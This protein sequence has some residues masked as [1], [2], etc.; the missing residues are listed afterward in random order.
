MKKLLSLLLLLLPV[1]AFAQTLPITMQF[2]GPN[3]AVNSKD[4]IQY[5]YTGKAGGP[6][7]FYNAEYIRSIFQHKITLTNTGSSGPSTL[8]GNTLNIPNYS[9]GTT[10]NV[11]TFNNSGS[12][13]S[14]GATFNGA[15]AITISYNSI[16]AQVAGT[17]LTPSSTNTV[18]NKDLT[19]GTNT[20]PTFNQ[21][22][23]G[24]AGSVANAITNGYGVLT[25]TYNGSSAKTIIIDSTILKS[26][27]SSLADYNILMTGINGKFTLPSLTN[28][29]VLFSNGTTISQDNNNFYYD[30]STHLLSVG[31]AGDFSGSNTINIYGAY[32]AYEPQ[33]AIGTVTNATLTPGIS[34]STSRGTG[35]SP[36]INNTGDLIGT[37]SFWAYTGSSPAYTYMAGI[38]GTAVGTTSTNLGGQLDFYVKANNGS[39]SSAMTILNSGLIGMGITTPSAGLLSVIKST[40]AQLVL[41]ADNVSSRVYF[42][43]DAAGDHLTL[44]S[45]GST[46]N[47]LL[48]VNGNISN[49]IYSISSNAFNST[50]ALGSNGDRWFGGGSRTNVANYLYGGASFNTIVNAFATQINVYTLTA[51]DS[52]TESYFGSSGVRTA[53]T[54][55][56]AWVGE[57]AIQAPL[58]STVTPGSSIPTNTNAL[59]LNNANV[60]SSGTNNWAAANNYALYVNLGKVNIQGLTATKIIFTDANKNLTSTG[61]GTSSQFLMADGSLNSSTYLTSLSGAILTTGSQTSLTGDKNSNANWVFGTVGV[62]TGT[63]TLAGKLQTAET[64]TSTIR[65]AIFGQ[66][67]SDANG[68]KIYGRKARGTV[69][70]PTVITTGDNLFGLNGAGFDGTNY[71]DA[72]RILSGT[73]GTISTGIIP[74]TLSF[75]TANSSGTLATAL[76]IDQAQN[77]TS[78]FEIRGV[79]PGTA[80]DGMGPINVTMP[81]D[82]NSYAMFGITR[83]SGT[84]IGLGMDNLNAFII[85]TGS[86]RGNGATITNIIWRQNTLTGDVQTPGVIQ[87]AGVK[88]STGIGANVFLDD[89]TTVAYNNNYTEGTW[90]PTATTTLGTATGSYIKIG[91]QVTAYF[92]IVINTNASASNFSMSGLPFTSGA[93]G[94]GGVTISTYAP[95]GTALT[96]P[97]FGQIGTDST[98][99]NFSSNAGLLTNLQF[100][101]SALYGYVTYRI[102]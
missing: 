67:S 27:A 100:S 25:L 46:A 45:D 92:R 44:S 74:G 3:P 18:T 12:G 76:F 33:S 75:Q 30:S 28:H 63:T 93:G 82:G 42:T 98:T 91:N 41:G 57:V 11:L 61:I 38:V 72:T 54:G 80:S 37:H 39:A 62:N 64:S 55:T 36:L 70:S 40:G 86:G 65:G 15:S 89:G 35:A 52:F 19:S 73:A 10:T 71:I 96:I 47:S 69:A 68:S 9:G 48:V 14:S 21:N 58:P 99:V 88:T 66:F 22:T 81:A 8:I 90:T 34:A 97:I 101:N 29:S 77:T 13:S 60:G 50:N 6:S 56:H 16:G 102:N 1:F 84:A 24:Q 85:G 83:A 20:F 7:W 49:S 87:L 23:T 31:V 79:N 5:N 51:G 53:S 59:Y 4:S 17:Y 2:K 32:D 26:K 78:S 43:V 94:E 95:S